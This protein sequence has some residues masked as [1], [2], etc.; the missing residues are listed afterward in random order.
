MSA[1]TCHVSEDVWAELRLA[2]DRI[3][4][5]CARIEREA[6]CWAVEHGVCAPQ[7]EA[8]LLR[9]HFPRLAARIY[10]D[11]PVER[12]VTVA[13]WLIVLF[14]LDDRFDRHDARPDDVRGLYRELADALTRDRAAMRD[15]LTRAVEPLWQGTAA[16]MSE[17]WRDRFVRN[18]VRH[19]EALEWE[20][21]LRRDAHAPTVAGYFDLRPWA[22]G[23]FM[24]DL[25]EP[26]RGQEVPVE[27]S[28]TY[29]WHCLTTCSNEITAWRNDLVSA[30]REAIEGNPNNQL[31]VMTHALG[32]DEAQANRF[33]EQHISG[34]VRELRAHAR[35]LLA[36]DAGRT[37]RLAEI[38][39]TMLSLTAAHARWV[40][41][42]GRYP[43]P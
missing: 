43:N 21:T 2:P 36:L 8:T 33:V 20:A 39:G 7:S 41:E 18:L 25:V 42:S 38:T 19:G 30:A 32:C 1:S 16:G 23:M 40:I 15:P 29:Q 14:A 27:L 31:S 28:V 34:R 4:A 13:R 35:S 22:N 6:H 3:H 17:A 9:A 26:T 37:P 24:W 12:V 11:A 5:D 10:H